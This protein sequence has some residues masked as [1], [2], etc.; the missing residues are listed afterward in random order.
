M[1]RQF[2]TFTRLSALRHLDL[3]FVRIREVVRGYTESTGC[4][5]FDGRTHRVAVRKTVGS[6]WIFST[7][8][9]VGFTTQSVHCNGEGGVCFHGDRT[10]GHGT[11]TEATDDF[12]PRLDLFERD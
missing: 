11:G 7:F 5:L 1:S 9:G 4:N 6:L 12:C 2:P 3:E 8:T 10:V